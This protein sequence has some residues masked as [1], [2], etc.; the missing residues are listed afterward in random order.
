M[1][2]ITIARMV[3]VCGILF[4]LP[5]CPARA[6]DASAWAVKDASIRFMLDLTVS[7]SHPSAG[8]FVTIPDGGILPGPEPE[9]S[10]F[11]DKGTPLASG[12]LWHNSAKGCGLVFQAPV[13]GRSAVI[14]FSGSSKL[15]V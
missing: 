7:P 5:M 3:V 9:P 14:Y 15:K 4:F 2:K 11:D 8:Y 13:A 1:I 6:A 10:V 12:V